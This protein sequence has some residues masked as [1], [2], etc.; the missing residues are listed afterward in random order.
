MSTLALGDLN[1]AQNALLNALLD[2][3]AA[4]PGSPAEGQVY[5]NTTDNNFYG[6]DGTSWVDLGTTGGGGGD[7]TGPGVSVNGELAVYSGTSGTVIDRA[8]LTGLLKAT[9]GVLQQAVAGTD[10]TTP[11]SAET[12]T[13][14]TIDANGAGNDISNLEVDDFAAGVVSTD[15]GLAGASDTELATSLA[16]KTYVDGILSASDA[17]VFAGGLDCSTNPNYPA[18]DAGDTYKVTV[19]GLIGGG[20]GVAVTVGDTLYCTVD[21]S[22]SGDHATVGAN[23]TIVQSNV[24]AATETTLGLAEY[25]TTAET[26]GRAATGVAVQPAGLAIFTKRYAE[27]VGDGVATVIAVTHNL[28]TKDVLV[29]LRRLSDD[30]FATADIVATSTSVVTIT[31]GSPPAT[32]D[33]RVTVLG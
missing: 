27:D 28:G 6:W 19:A 25:A 12:L 26:E 21:S 20:S 1:L 29:Q 8:S 22:A 18:A 24:D 23:W 16:I 7:V 32:D 15:T 10:Y 33:I 9:A 11:S 5:F 2:P 13:N 4:A 31:F 17:M 14:K 3:Q 30:R